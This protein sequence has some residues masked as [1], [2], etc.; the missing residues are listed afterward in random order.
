MKYHFKP[1]LRAI[2]VEAVEDKERRMEI[3]LNNTAKLLSEDEIADFVNDLGYL[4]AVLTD[5]RN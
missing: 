5:L 2:I 4:K 1:W 3:A